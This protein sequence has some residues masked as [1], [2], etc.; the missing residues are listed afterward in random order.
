VTD[1][2]R[3]LPPD[4]DATQIG[5]LG[6]AAAPPDNVPR[7]IGRYRPLRILGRGGMGVVYEAEQDEPRRRVALKVIRPELATDD[8]QRRFAHE[9]V[10]L[11]RLQHPGIAQVYEA[12]T[13][14]TERGPVPFIAMELVEGLPL[15]TWVQDQKPDRPARVELM[16]RLCD[17]VQHA[18]QRG[19][20]HRDLKPGN[21]LVDTRGR[22]RVLDFG[23]ARPHDADLETSLVT[24]HGEL[25]GT[26]AYMSPEQLAGDPDDIDTRS[27]VYALGVIL[28]QLLADRPPL[29]L[30]GRSLEEVL[31]SVREVDPPSLASHDP[32]LAGDLS[33]ITAT[34][35]AK[36]RTQRYAS[37]NGLRA[38]LQRFLDDQPIAARPPSTIYQ[39]KKFT[40]RHRPLV[41]GVVGVA[42]ALVLGVVISTWQAVRATQAE[43]LAEAR[44]EQAESVTGFLQDMLAAVD[45]QE[46]RGREVTVGEV[47]DRAAEDIEG[48]SLA[49]QTAVEMAL[50]RTLG[51][52]YQ[53]LGDFDTALHHLDRARAVADSTQGP[54]A[55]ETQQLVVDVA[56]ARIRLGLLEQAES[57]I[58]PL[59]PDLPPGSKVHR[60]ALTALTEIRY[61]AGHWQAADSLQ[62]VVL[63]MAVAAA[64]VDS[65]EVGT[66]LLYLAF[67]AEQQNELDRAAALVDRAEPIYRAHLGDDHPRLITVLNRRGEIATGGG[68]YQEALPPLEESLAIADAVYEPVHPLRADV[69]SRL[70]TVYLAMR[71]LDE[72]AAA[73]EEALAIRREVLGPTHR[74]IALA[75]TSL[76][77]AESLRND[78]DRA[79]ALQ[80]EA[81]AMRRE[82]F[83]DDHVAVVDSYGN[84]GQIAMQRGAPAE[85]ESLYVEATDMLERIPE[86]TGDLKASF[87]H[88]TAMAIQGQGEHDRAEA[89]F[90][91]TI[92]LHRESLGGEHWLVA[93]GMSNLVT[94]LFRQGR[95]AEAADVQQAAL[96]MQRR[97]GASGKSLVLSLG[98]VAFLLDDAGRHAEADT[99]Y[100]EYIALATE[101]FGEAHPYPPDARGRYS[102]NLTLRGRHVEA[103]E[104]A[105]DLV[106][107][108]LENLPAVDARRTTGY[109]YLVAPLVGQGR[110]AEAD[111]LLTMVEDYL[112]GEHA[113]QPKELPKLQTMVD[114]ARAT[115][116]GARAGG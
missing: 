98:N 77:Q 82:V 80:Y 2:D 100:Q 94:N 63:E 17:A 53:T 16:I 55:A 44:L 95:K 60:Q 54:A 32:Q 39:L 84:L 35:M 8:L 112:A 62:Q 40:R 99:F 7:R 47:L 113:V 101:T 4:P 5:D 71:R 75:L 13:A 18:H 67:L 15:D 68:L 57:L 1:D 109:V 52:T 30:A 36:D 20:I 24:T 29:D 58:A 91:R 61:T 12:G 97:I 65:L 9:S 56:S 116:R 42:A 10:F 69:L 23:V 108:R 104:Q 50:R 49:D 38:D 102:K 31:R 51:L 19:L 48:G 26:L 89:Y 93:R 34:A 70:G 28:Y 103:E 106:A 90:R 46:A 72:S 115:V 14:P 59:A 111:S 88:Y 33:I 74:D 85:A 86:E 43:R 27:D 81:L 6:S 41:F 78:L 64:D 87:A 73:F 21:V 105:R 76:G 96:A 92:E 22:P 25:V 66:V 11:A 107:W 37:A 79:E 3:T 114:G 110:V 45:P 83:G